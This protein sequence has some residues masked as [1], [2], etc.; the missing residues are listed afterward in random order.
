M[1]G[2]FQLLLALMAQRLPRLHM[3]GRCV[4][5]NIQLMDVMRKVQD[6]SIKHCLNG[7]KIDRTNFRMAR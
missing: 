2:R 6:C 5:G 7:G 4:Y 1:V 3:I